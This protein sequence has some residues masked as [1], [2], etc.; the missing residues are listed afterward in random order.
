MCGGIGWLD[1]HS[2]CGGIGWLDGHSVCE[3]V[4]WTENRSGIVC[5]GVRGSGAKSEV[6][7]KG[8]EDG[9]VRGGRWWQGV[10]MGA[11]DGGGRKRGGVWG[12][13]GRWRTEWGLG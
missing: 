3:G 9:R 6:E 10:G 8:E 7:D 12:R 2:V 5:R 1:G 11:E 13:G 4:G